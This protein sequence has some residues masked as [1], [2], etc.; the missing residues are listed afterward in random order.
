MHH[1]HFNSL[2]STQTYLRAHL[3]QLKKSHQDILISTASQT[4][5]KG[6]NANTWNFYSDSL[7]MS[8]TLVPNKTPSLTPLEIG[9]LAIDFFKSHFSE[10]MFIKWPNDLLNSSS[11]KC[12]GILTQYLDPQTVIAG[13]GINIGETELGQEEAKNFK[14]GLGF[15][16]G[17]SVNT[18][19]QKTLSAKFYQFILTNRLSDSNELRKRFNDV[20]AHLNKQVV[21]HDDHAEYTGLFK[22]VGPN[23]EAEVEINGVIKPFYSSS[24]TII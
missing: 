14:H 16:L 12:G 11:L 15:L 10:E 4:G 9:L 7:A 23:G 24:L 20:C 6:R 13:V 8:F 19:D 21:V 1:S 17:S 18:I 22:S 3:D 5:G 2:E